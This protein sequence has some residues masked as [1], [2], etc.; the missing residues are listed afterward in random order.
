MLEQTVEESV[1]TVARLLESAATNAISCALGARS[2][3]VGKKHLKGAAEKQKESFATRPPPEA[4][5]LWVP[6]FQ[7]PLCLFLVSVVIA[8]RIQRK[9]SV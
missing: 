2:C 9:S 6:Q 5:A 7:S 1:V 8:F 4:L 3:A